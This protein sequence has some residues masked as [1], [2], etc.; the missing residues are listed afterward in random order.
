MLYRTDIEL[1]PGFELNFNM[2]SL[3][4]GAM[5]EQVREHGHGDYGDRLHESELHPYTQHL[6]LRDGVWHWVLTFLDDESHGKIWQDS[7]SGLGAAELRDKGQTIPFGEIREESMSLRD[8][9][10]IFT[11][12][13]DA[14]G[15]GLS[16]VTP[17]CFR[18]NGRYVF[19]PELSF[20]LQSAMRKYDAV[21]EGEQLYDH[22]TLDDLCGGTAIQSFSLKSRLISLEGVRIPGFTGRMTLRCPRSRTM[23]GFLS[24]LMT[25]AGFPGI[26]IKTGMGMGAVRTEICPRKEARN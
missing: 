6:E 2:S 14:W 12:G 1:R 4:Q 22:E 20:I 5:M 24:M 26:G 3:F 21:M 11:N 17:T 19:M 18:S 25:F 7:L 23:T 8:L 15:I 16:F 10:E 9:N 13:A